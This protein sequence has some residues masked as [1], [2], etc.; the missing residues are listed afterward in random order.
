ME[1]T[2][3]F[4]SSTYLDVYCTN[5][6]PLPTGIFTYLPQLLFS[7][8]RVQ[9]TNKYLQHYLKGNGRINTENG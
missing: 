6:N 9:V 5:P 2:Y 4:Y 7:H 3:I 1:E 8:I